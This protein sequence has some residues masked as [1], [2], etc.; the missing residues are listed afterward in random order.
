[1]KQT[2]DYAHTIEVSDV[3]VFHRRKEIEK[4]RTFDCIHG[5]KHVN[6]R[7]QV[8]YF[9]KQCTVSIDPVYLSCSDLELFP[10]TVLRSLHE[11]LPSLRTILHF[12]MSKTDLSEGVLIFCCLPRNNIS[13]FTVT[14]PLIL[15]RSDL[16]F[17]SVGITALSPLTF[18]N[19]LTVSV[20]H[21]IIPIFTVSLTDCHPHS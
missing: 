4:N 15:L 3:L 10:F 11:P 14:T 18:S 7:Q 5:T 17:L 1:M 2:F 9:H 8:T 20:T 6:H 21:T 19:T 13:F 12:D 16:L